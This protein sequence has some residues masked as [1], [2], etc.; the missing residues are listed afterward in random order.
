MERK[1]IRFHTDPDQPRKELLLMAQ[2]WTVEQI[3][4]YH[5]QC[6]V[7]HRALHG[8]TERERLTKGRRIVIRKLEN[9]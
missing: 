6:K 7:Q 9:Y 8:E 4:E 2:D 5:E 3:L 1:K